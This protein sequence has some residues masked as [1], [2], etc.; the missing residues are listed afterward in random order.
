MDFV[1]VG[2]GLFGSMTARALLSD[3][4]RVMVVDDRITDCS[5]AS[6][7]IIKPSWLMGVPEAKRKA[8]LAHLMYHYQGPK[9][10]REVDFLVLPLR[11]TVTA[12]H[13]PPQTVLLPDDEVVSDIVV[14]VH[15]G[16][17]R[18]SYGTEYKGI[19]IVCAGTGTTRLLPDI[20]VKGV[21]GISLVFPGQLCSPQMRVWAPYKQAVC[22]NNPD[23]AW[24]G[25]GTAIQPEKWSDN[26]V[27]RAVEQAEAFF[28]LT[29]MMRIQVG[30][31]PYVEGQNGLLK[32]ISE[33]L[34]VN[35]GGA[36]SGAVLAAAHAEEIRMTYAHEL[37][38]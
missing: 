19:V 18:C 33:R 26:Y 29:G 2:A 28:G 3:G 30:A 9:G 11:K 13:L 37:F 34:W 7:C 4:H 24:F 5:K 8:G 21:M 32:Q 15:D 12:W 6:G 22:I 16:V 38:R 36:K 23:G 31:R 10:M 25:N 14:G 27:D 17:V 35:T 20:H 1:I